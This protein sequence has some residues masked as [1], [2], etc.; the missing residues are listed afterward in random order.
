MGTFSLFYRFSIRLKTEN[1]Y[2]IIN[3]SNKVKGF[4]QML[5]YR[6]TY[7]NSNS[8]FNLEYDYFKYNYK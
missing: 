7:N 1:N 4:L 3:E 5:F 2:I 8:I 6:D